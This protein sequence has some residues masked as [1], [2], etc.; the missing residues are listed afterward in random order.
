MPIGVIPFVLDDVN[1][2]NVPPV[3]AVAPIGVLKLAAVHGFGSTP[4]VG[5]CAGHWVLHSVAVS[6]LL[7]QPLMV[8][9]YK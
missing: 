6:G 3:L 9:V 7:S 8:W 1:Q 2:Y 4:G 5:A